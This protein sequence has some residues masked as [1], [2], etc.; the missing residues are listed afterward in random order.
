MDAFQIKAEI[1]VFLTEDFESLSLGSMDPSMRASVHRLAKALDLKSHSRGSGD[2]RHPILTKT[3][4]TPHYTLAT[5]SEIDA[6]MDKR[7]FFTK[8][9]GWGS[10][11]ATPKSSMKI[12]RGGGGALAGASYM[13]GEVVGASAPELGAE[14]KG[15][16]LLQKMGWTS[17]QA[18]G[19]LG[20]KGSIEVIKHV[21]KNTKAGLG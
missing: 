9:G 4:R 3:P 2:D 16:A 5:I 11:K 1:R 10:S 12:R 21:V 18:I 17:G 19:A 7:K 20:N 8:S 14:N 15:F 6:L 13:D